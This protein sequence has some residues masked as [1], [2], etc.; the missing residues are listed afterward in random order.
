MWRCPIPTAEQATRAIRAT[1]PPGLHVPID[2]LTADALPGDRDKCFTAGMDGFIAKPLAVDQVLQLVSRL[3]AGTNTTSET[4]V[5]LDP[6]D[7]AHIAEA[8]ECPIPM[9]WG[10]PKVNLSIRAMA[11]AA[12]PSSHDSCENSG[13]RHCPA[14]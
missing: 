8:N 6:E 10:V 12:E 11:T 9:N 7:K 3:A 14:L 4:D 1:E 5:A 13:R 2:A